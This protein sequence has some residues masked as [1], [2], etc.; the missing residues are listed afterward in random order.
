M[1]KSLSQQTVRAFALIGARA[2]LESL[3]AEIEALRASFPELGGGG[4]GRGRR[5]ARKTAAASSRKRRPR[6]R[7]TA[8]E[9]QAVSE[10]MRKYWAG[11]R[12]D[13]GK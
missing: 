13:K 7:M 10:R 2:R 3:Q 1:A 6:R 5:R 8:E 12:K 11:R 4:T 9:K